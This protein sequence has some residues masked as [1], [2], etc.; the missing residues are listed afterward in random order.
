LL[1]S[2]QSLIWRKAMIISDLNHLEVVSQETS[3]LGGFDQGY[4]FSKIYFDEYFNIDK[5]VYSKVYAKGSLAT[6]ESNAD[7][8]GYGTVAQVFT[9][10]FTSPYQ[11]SAN[12]VSISATSY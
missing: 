8:V 12:G 9:N 7:A 5:N 3:V 4:D 11:S 2:E 6:A 10:T 1:Q